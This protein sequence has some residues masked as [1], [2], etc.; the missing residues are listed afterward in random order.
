MSD[1]VHWCRVVMNLSIERF[2]ETLECS[3]VDCLEISGTRFQHGGQA[4]RSYVSTGFP[5][6]DV[7]AG[8]LAHGSF[9]LIICEQVLEH[10]LRPDLAVANM[11]AMLRP[12]GCLVVNTPFLLK[13]HGFPHDLWRWTEHGL[14]Q[15]LELAG[16]VGVETASWGNRACLVADLS[17][18]LRWTVFD[19]TRHS[20]EN[21]PQFPIVVWAI[22]RRQP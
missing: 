4:F 3:A 22:A 17:D 14:R 18:G 9:D 15:L 12:G 11:L 20:L 16:F 13:V 19:P 21:E 8:P 5:A 6:Y 2:I 1:W 10:V 7:C